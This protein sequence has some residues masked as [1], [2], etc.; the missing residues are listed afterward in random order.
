LFRHIEIIRPKCILLL[1]ATA[2]T[3]VLNYIG[4][5]NKIRGQWQKIKVINTYFNIL[6]TFHPAYLLRQPS[7]K[8]I[9]LKDLAEIK[10]NR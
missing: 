4:P 2:A 8:K 9:I 5:L 1:G 6:T 3:A 10:K 7:K